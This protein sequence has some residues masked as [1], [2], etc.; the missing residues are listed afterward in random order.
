MVSRTLAKLENVA[1][2]IRETF[3][4]KTAVIDVDFTSSDIY[5]KIKD[6]IKGKEIGILVNNVGMCYSTP[7]YFLEYPEREKFIKDLIN[8]NILSMTMMCS[9]ILPQMVQRSKGIVINLGSTSTVIPAPNL[10]MYSGS[11][12]FIEKF[13]DDLAAEYENN[14]IIMQFVQPGFVAS[15]M[16]KMEKGFIVISSSKDFVH[17]ALKTVGFAKKTHGLFTHY[18]LKLFLMLPNYLSPS[19]YRVI[20]REVLKYH[21]NRHIRNGIY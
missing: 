5:N 18:I 7:D 1:E 11:K 2:E 19:L 21:R 12:A 8:C 9:I 17:A 6:C 14:G 13:S 4:V 10:T 20:A 15:N 3:G 16:T